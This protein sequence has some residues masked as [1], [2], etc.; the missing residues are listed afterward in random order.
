[1]R[2]LIQN[3]CV[4]TVNPQGDVLEGG[5]VAIGDDGLIHS[6]GPAGSEPPADGARV[7][8]ARG[9]FVAPGLIN[10][11]QHLHMNLLKGLADG[12]LL[13]PWVF[14]FSAVGR[15]FMGREDVRTSTSLAAMEMLR[16]GTTCVLNHQTT[17]GWSEVHHDAAELLAQAGLRQVLAVAF[18]CRTPKMPDHPWSAADATRNIG[19]LVDTL[20]GANAGMTRAALVVE[21]NAHHTEAGRS[22]DELV[23]A[24]Y[25]LACDKDLR[26]AVHMS[27]GTLSMHM[28]FTKYRRQTGRSDVGYLEGLGV[29]DHR[30]LL[31]HGIHFSDD[32]IAIVAQRGASVVY[33]P[34]SEAIRGGGLGHWRAMLDAGVTCTLGTDG[35]AV[36]YSVDM[37]EQM[38]ACCYLQSVRYGD[39]AAVPPHV[40]LQMATI[41]AARALGM[42][43]AIGSLEVGKQAD[44][45]LFDRAR[46]HLRMVRDPVTAFV[47]AS[48]GADA[49]LVVVGGRVVYED[50]EYPT[51]PH[52]EALMADARTRSRKVARAADFERLAVPRW[53]Q[54]VG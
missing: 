54:V 50:G 48:R 43:H 9:G 36:D 38:K 49:R 53:P 15:K 11:H 20:D 8:D 7:I 23:R 33:T 35:P 26:I 13:E 25:A 37:V 41:N 19:A 46:P 6:V 17:F 52:A 45:V 18:Q 12:M 3:A 30:W 21:C 42:A 5:F 51:L 16:T 32:D 2:T 47:R 4:I 14:N 1:M 29:L 28:G 34:T 44:L 10:L 22:S 27:G 31:K 39:P 24:G 40:A